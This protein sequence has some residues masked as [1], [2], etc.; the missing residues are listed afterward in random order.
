MRGTLPLEDIR[1]GDNRD[2]PDL[3][4]PLDAVSQWWIVPERSRL[5]QE[6]AQKLVGYTEQVSSHLLFSILIS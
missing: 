4:I 1:V 6:L 2:I 3:G 5:T